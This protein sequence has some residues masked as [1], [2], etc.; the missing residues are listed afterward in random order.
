MFGRY[1]NGVSFFQVTDGLSNTI[2]VG[3]SLPRECIFFSAFATNFNL[4]PTNIPINQPAAAGGPLETYFLN[5]GFK[6]RHPGGAN[7]ALADGSVTFLSE[8]IDFVLYNNLGTRAGGEPVLA[9]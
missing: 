3:E 1:K 7:F 2:M 5:C 9:P 8:T 6:S 4:A